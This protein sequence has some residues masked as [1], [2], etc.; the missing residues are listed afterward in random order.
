MSTRGAGEALFL[1]DV[2]G[3]LLRGDD[4]GKRAMRAA[5]EALFGDS[6]GFDGLGFGGLT[7][8]HIV[9]RAAAAQGLALDPTQLRAALERYRDEME[10]RVAAESGAFRAI[11][12]ACAVARALGERFPGR[13]GLGTGNMAAIAALKVN[14]VGLGEVFTFG[15]YGDDAEDRAE[16]LAIGWARGRAATGLGPEAARVV[17]IG[18]TVRD[19]AAA[20]AIG[21]EVIAV[22]TGSDS[23]A[24][25]AAAAPDLLLTE[26][27]LSAVLGWLGAF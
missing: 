20:R 3:T 1:W 9:R 11:D 2:D 8:L 5:F 16:M 14:R 18:D 21:A 15:G 4:I 7:D 26:L 12:T 10:Q 13:S 27:E 17:V 6:R 22:A 23:T 25:L 24:K 19:I